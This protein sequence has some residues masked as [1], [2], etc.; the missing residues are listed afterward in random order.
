MLLKTH[1][2][3]ALLFVIIFFN[4]V[5]D[6]VVFIIVMAVATLLPNIDN[7]FS[8]I[9]KNVIFKPVQFFTK[10]RGLF[11]SFTLAIILSV[12]LAIFIPVAS[13][14]FFLGYSIHLMIDSFTR[15]GIQPF[16]PYKAISKGFIPTGGKV[17]DSIFLFFVVVD[18]LV[19]A[20]IFIFV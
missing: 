8:G 5:S 20:V 13:F 12:L 19:F 17:E 7:P 18:I 15:E 3:I 10:H 16:W 6:K 9:G 2:A 14:G 4:Y 1:L 11:H